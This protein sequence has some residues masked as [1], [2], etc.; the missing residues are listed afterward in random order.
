MQP[1]AFYLIVHALI[2]KVNGKTV[3]KYIHPVGIF[4]FCVQIDGIPGDLAV[5]GP[6]DGVRK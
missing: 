6:H 5:T 1:V 4:I 2:A 3:L